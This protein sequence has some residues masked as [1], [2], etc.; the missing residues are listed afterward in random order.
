MDDLIRRIA[1]HLER[2]LPFVVFSS[3]DSMEMKAYLQKDTTTYIYDQNSKACFVFHPFDTSK[4]AYTIPKSAAEIIQTPFEGIRR[5]PHPVEI[6]DNPNEQDAYEVLVQKALQWLERK[7]TMKIVTSRRHIEKVDKLDL[8][9]LIVSLFSLYPTAYR[10]VWYHPK[11]GLWCGAT[12]EL[13]LKSDGECFNTMALAGTQYPDALGRVGWTEKEREEQQMVVDDIVN[14]L[15]K[16]LSVIKISKTHNHLAGTV[17]HLR[18]DISGCIKKGKNTLFDIVESLHPTPAVCG[19]PTLKAKQFIT[20]FE[21]YDREFYT[22]FLG[23]LGEKE[24]N[25]SLYVNLRCMKI[26]EGMA[27]IYVGGG[28]TRASVPNLEWKETENKLQTMLQVLQP[29]L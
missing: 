8:Q 1:D 24:V 5:S 7:K 11:T 13:L 29:L 26:E 12:P 22:G 10:Y 23:E 6:H 9:Q 2:R 27:S 17:M 28:I 4:E 21:G 15:Q 18:T 20:E 3:P 16:V 14:K 25:T 19:A